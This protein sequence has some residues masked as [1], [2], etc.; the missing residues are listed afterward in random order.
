MFALFNI[1]FIKFMYE[2]Y[3]CCDTNFF[4]QIYVN[5]ILASLFY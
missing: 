1:F 5:N 3:I 2:A 4:K